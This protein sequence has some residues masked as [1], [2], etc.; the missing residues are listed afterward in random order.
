MINALPKPKNSIRVFYK[1]NVPTEGL[2]YCL[3]F[4][5][6]EDGIDI[7]CWNHID[8]M[9]KCGMRYRSNNPTNRFIPDIEGME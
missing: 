5:T 8:D 1:E 4:N 2:L 6:K 9:Y 7:I 3:D